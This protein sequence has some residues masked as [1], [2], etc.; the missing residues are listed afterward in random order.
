MEVVPLGWCIQS[1]QRAVERVR[2]TGWNDVI[3]QYAAVSETLFWI[4]I[5]EAR[6]R[7]K[8]PQH[9]EAALNDRPSNLRPLLRGLL[10]ARNRITHEVDEIHY[11]L[12]KAKSAHGFEAKWTWQSLPARPAG[13]YQDPDGHAAYESAVV[14]RDVVDTLLDVTVCLGQ[15]STR[16][17]M[18]YGNSREV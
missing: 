12:A 8:Y 11:F 5:V 18:A 9:Y 4:D 15:A 10:W 16:M 13:P 2:G 6:L 1:M 3:G 17:W 14:G 7:T